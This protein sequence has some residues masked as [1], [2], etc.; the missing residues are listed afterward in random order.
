MQ[1]APLPRGH[2]FTKED[3]GPGVMRVK[4]DIDSLLL[5]SAKVYEVGCGYHLSPRY[6]CASKHIQVMTAS[7][8]HVTASMGFT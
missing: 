1:L 6:Y 7:V 2:H 4:N 5:E 3:I 8:V